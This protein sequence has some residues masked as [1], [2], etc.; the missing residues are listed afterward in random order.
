MTKIIPPCVY[1]MIYSHGNQHNTFY[2]K[3][4]FKEENAIKEVDNERWKGY[5]KIF[6]SDYEEF[7]KEIVE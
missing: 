1:V 6:L 2:G 4:F 3:V 5:R 7:C